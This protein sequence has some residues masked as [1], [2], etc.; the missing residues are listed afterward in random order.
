MVKIIS[1]KMRKDKYA[2]RI[3]LWRVTFI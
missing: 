1:E 3:K 2:G